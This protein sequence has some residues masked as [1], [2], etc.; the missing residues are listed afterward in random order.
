MC[1]FTKDCIGIIDLGWISIEL[2]ADWIVGILYRIIGL[3]PYRALL[4]S[5]RRYWF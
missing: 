4:R 5:K 2:N 1:D 3:Y